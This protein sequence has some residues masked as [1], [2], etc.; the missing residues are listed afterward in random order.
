MKQK[1]T[2][3]L[4]WTAFSVLLLLL[5]VILVFGWIQTNP[6]RKQV[7]FV[8]GKMLSSGTETRVEFRGLTGF[9]PLRFRV[10]EIMVSDSLGPWLTATHVAA[11]WH[12]QDLLHGYIRF[13]SIRAEAVDFSRTPGTGKPRP[14]H[15]PAA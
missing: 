6:G 4:K 15:T 9:F 12:P 3:G 13:K 10:D 7:A 11:R 8:F 2:K 1:I 5:G 14:I